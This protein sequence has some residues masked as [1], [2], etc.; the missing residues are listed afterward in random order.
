MKQSPSGEASCR[1]EETAN[2]RYA[3]FLPESHGK[4]H[5]Y[6]AKLEPD[7]RVSIDGLPL[8]DSQ[9]VPTYNRKFQRHVYMSPT[10]PC[11]K[12]YSYESSPDL[13]SPFY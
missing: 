10:S 5:C 3:I 2:C 6:T 13:P 11:P 1:L 4:F 9:D 8:S 7:R 12:P